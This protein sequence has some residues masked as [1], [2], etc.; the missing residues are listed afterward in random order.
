[1][2]SP[3][4]HSAAFLV[5]LSGLWVAIRRACGHFSFFCASNQFCGCC[6]SA[7]FSSIQSS[8]S[9]SADADMLVANS[10]WNESTMP[11]APVPNLPHVSPPFVQHT[12]LRHGLPSE[13]LAA[14][15]S[16]VAL[17]SMADHHMCH[18]SCT[19]RSRCQT[20]SLSLNARAL[21]V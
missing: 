14:L 21:S 1:M 2:I 10:L 4:F 7:F 11:K 20:L 17:S 16:H 18:T 15:Q 12:S 13:R 5:H 19:A 8:N 6:V 3:G 9:S